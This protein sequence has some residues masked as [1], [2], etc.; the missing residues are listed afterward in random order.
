MI[1]TGEYADTI[2]KVE[3]KPLNEAMFT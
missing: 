3:M 1:P 2:N